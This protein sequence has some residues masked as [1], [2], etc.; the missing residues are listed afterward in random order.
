MHHAIVSSS[1]FS[2]SSY[3]PNTD[4]RH[5]GHHGISQTTNGPIGPRQW[6]QIF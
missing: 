2:V 6:G 4:F 5:L 1:Q 3:L